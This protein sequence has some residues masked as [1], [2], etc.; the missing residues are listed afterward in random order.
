MSDED[1]ALHARI[2]KIEGQLH[3]IGQVLCGAAG[4]IPAYLAYIFVAQQLQLLPSLAGLSAFVVWAIV[5]S[6]L[7]RLFR[8][9]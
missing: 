8:R 4:F 6:V 9:H 3:F 2:S 7:W 1:P 5:G